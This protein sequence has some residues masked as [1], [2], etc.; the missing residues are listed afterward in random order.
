MSWL[1]DIDIFQRTGITDD[2]R[3]SLPVLWMFL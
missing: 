3:I 2:S 1:S